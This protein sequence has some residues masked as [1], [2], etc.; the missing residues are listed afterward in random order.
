MAV[1]V[2]GSEITLSGSVGDLWFEDGFTAAEVIAAL[3]QVGD[4]NDVTIRLNSGGGIATEGSAIHA[5]IAR[6]K[7]TKTIV[8]EGVAASAGSLIAMAGDI[9]EMALGSTMMIHDPSGLTFGTA[10]D[11]EV[12]LRA[13]N[14]MADAFAGVYAAKSGRTAAQCRADMRLEL[15]LTPEEAVAQGYADRVGAAANDNEPAEAVAAFDYRIYAHAPK[16]LVAL[17]RKHDWRMSAGRSPAASA[18][19]TPDKEKPMPPE[20]TTGAS[21]PED[22]E[23]ARRTATSAAAEIATICA[24]AGVPAMTAQLIREGV[25]ADQA[26][27]RACQAKDIRMAVDLAR[28]KDTKIEANAADQ[29]IA[30]GKSLDQVRAA[31]FERFVA[32]EEQTAINPTSP[33][34]SGQEGPKSATA[35]MQRQLK[36][37]GMSQEA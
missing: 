15:W 21:T 27:A 8:I 17:A 16:E 32:Q 28:K 10:A 18:A 14:A 33:L 9:V 20:Q 22:I 3:A 1:L 31:L 26:R 6:H 29:Y 30:Q 11:H 7:G 35:S 4:G 5:A 37:A 34:P 19:P 13:L 24:D 2:N 36:R 25:T 12:T 23:A